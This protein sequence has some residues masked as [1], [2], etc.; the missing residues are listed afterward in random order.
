ME[1]LEETLTYRDDTGLY[2]K[3]LREDGKGLADTHSDESN[4]VDLDIKPDVTK[5]VKV[6]F[7]GEGQQLSVKCD[8]SRPSEAKII[9]EDFV[10]EPSKDTR[11]T[12]VCAHVLDE[13]VTKLPKP[14]QDQEENSDRKDVDDERSDQSDGLRYTDMYLNSNSESDDGASTVLSDH[15]EYDTAEDESHYITTHK[16]QLIELDHDPDYDLGRGTWD[17]EDD[18]LV[19][20]FVDYASF[21]SDETQDGT[22]LAKAQPCVGGA[23]ISSEQEESE[24]ASSDESE[25]K[26]QSRDDVAEKVHVSIQTSSR[27]TESEPLFFSERA[28][29]S[30]GGAR[31]GPLTDPSKY[32]IPAPGRQHLA[33]KL[34]RKDINEYSSGASSSISEM[35]DADKE[36][37]NLTAKSFR[38]LACPYFDAINFST[39]SESSVSEYGLNKWSA[40]VDWNYGMGGERSLIAHKA[41]STT[42]GRR[43]HGESDPQ[44]TL[45]ERTSPPREPST[46]APP[47]QGGVTLS[48]PCNVE[49]ELHEGA[50]RSKSHHSAFSSAEATPG[51]AW[52]RSGCEINT[53]DTHKKAIFASSLLKN[54]ISKKMQFEQE[55]KMERGE[56]FD[57][58]PALSSSS[59]LKDQDATKEKMQTSTGLGFIPTPGDK[60][61]SSTCEPPEAEKRKK[62]QE[63]ACA[64]EKGQVEPPKELIC[65]QSSAFNSLKEQQPQLTKEAVSDAKEES[66]NKNMLSKLSQVFV[67]SCQLVSKEK[68]STEPVTPAGAQKCELNTSVSEEKWRQRRAPEIKICVRSVKENRGCTLNIA[69]LLTPKISLNTINALRAVGDSKYHVLSA[70][71]KFTNFTVGDTHRQ[72]ETQLRDTKCKFQTPIY[73]V[74]DVRKLV[75]SSYRFMSLDNSNKSSTAPP[76][77]EAKTEQVKYLLP[78]PI[79]IKY[80][81]VKTTTGGSQNRSE[82]GRL[83]PTIPLEI[84]HGEREPVMCATSRA[85][86][87]GAKQ[88][89]T[90][91][92]ESQTSSEVKQAKQRLEVFMGDTADRRHET[93]IPKQAALEKLKAAVK[94]MEQLYGFTNSEQKCKNEGLH[95]VADSRVVSLISRE[96]HGAGEFDTTMRS[97]RLANP[98]EKTERI[99]PGETPL[100]EKCELQKDRESLTNT[101]PTQSQQSKV[102]KNQSVLHFGQSSQTHVTS[103]FVSNT[104][105][106]SSAVHTSSA[107]KSSR[108]PVAPHTAK[109]E[110]PK[111]G[112]VG[113]GK[114]KVRPSNVTVAHDG[115]DSENYLTIPGL[116]YKNEIKLLNREQL[117]PSAVSNASQSL[118]GGTVRPEQSDQ[119]NSPLIT[120]CPASVYHHSAAA[121]PG[122]QTQQVLCFSPFVPTVSPTPQTERKMLLDPTT[123]HYYLVDTPVP[124]PTK[125]LYDPDTGQYVDVPMPHSPVPAPVTPVT[126]VTPV[127][128]S[129]SPLAVSSGAYTPTYMIYPGFIPSPTLQVQ[130]GLSQTSCQS[131]KA[132]GE[133]IKHA[134][135][136]SGQ[137]VNATSRESVY[138]SATAEA[139]SAPQQPSFTARGRATRSE[140]KPVISITTQQGPTVVTPPSFAGTS[141]VVE[142]R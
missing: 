117:L 134:T 63:D 1:V 17:F 79:V 90:Y 33:T 52:A 119:K 120:E 105:P 73:H 125:R 43:T 38:S 16:I 92:S 71:N 99:P 77:N 133:N 104:A 88:L 70:S 59:Q 44:T 29:D 27:T 40:Y 110:A 12:G 107:L 84:S 23:L 42:L 91:Q 141:F 124:A 51:T 142:H 130:T 80:H 81:S 138:Y 137:E 32:F 45:N 48:I 118:T 30:A 96:E 89:N 5:T 19:Y 87:T 121:T 7:T 47:Q 20:S 61:Q 136:Q 3:L 34:R 86:P 123:G 64:S 103:S 127:P 28:G 62:A 126:P 101:F 10:E 56:I 93:T 100:T 113:Q 128:L 129:L 41:F 131:E 31:A 21:E 57:T 122:L 49:E 72:T 22:S 115:S 46:D 109:I 4:Y 50:L 95:A 135:R 15:C 85:P 114:V 53:G 106:H 139:P 65:S 140:R 75:K 132:K 8:G 116:G 68:E 36:V 102:F 94:T 108:S 39:S 13:P 25:C 97:S 14:N 6:T 66:E 67:P 98:E 11:T 69:N 35:D 78:N 37:R 82:T 18:N 58:H 60:Q 54:V 83:S 24:C 9:S 112:Q 55:R 74:R 26:N 2:K 76:K 111:D